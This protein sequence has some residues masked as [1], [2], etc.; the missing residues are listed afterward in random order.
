MKEIEVAIKQLKC[1]NTQRPDDVTNDMIK[2]FGP[3]A[4]KTLLGLFNKQWKTGTVPCGV[5]CSNYRTEVLALLNTTETT[6]LWEEKLKKPAFIT[7]SLTAP[8]AL[9]PGEP[10][11]TLK[12]LTE[13]IN[14][15]AQSTCI[16]CSSVDT[17]THRIRG[18]EIVDQ[19]ANEGREKEQPHHIC[20]TAK[21]KRL[22]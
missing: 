12:K 19:L 22:P 17:S 10:D 3:A 5:L 6:N 20:P 4:R 11:T 1:K 15:L 13:N 18:N 14:T 7:D 8:Q 9:M 2:N 21:S 16:D